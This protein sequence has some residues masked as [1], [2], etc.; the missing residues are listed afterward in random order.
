MN[1]ETIDVFMLNN[2]ERLLYSMDRKMTKTQLLES[3][4]K[5]FDHL[6]LEIERGRIK[7]YGITS[8]SMHLKSSP[9]YLPLNDILA[10]PESKCS[11]IQYPFNVFENEAV[12]NG[13]D[14]S[15]SLSAQCEAR[16]IFQMTQRPLISITKTGVR[17]LTT[18]D[19]ELNE[20]EVNDVATRQF[21][22]LTEMEVDLGMMSILPHIYSC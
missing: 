9:D 19:E 17:K 15:E 16:K 3:I 1:L 21:E 22:V 7:S 8:N 10:F 4:Q 6:N 20:T 13:L 11:V 5:A 14:L 18:S 2:P 12:Q